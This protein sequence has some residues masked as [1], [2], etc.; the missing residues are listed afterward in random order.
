MTELKF[1]WHGKEVKNALHR[2]AAQ[3]IAKWADEVLKASQDEVPVSKWAR[4]GY[5]KS[6]GAVDMDERKLEATVS[7][8]TDFAVWVHERMD[9]NHPVGKAKFLEDPLNNVGGDKILQEA[10]KRELR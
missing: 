5:L 3:G 4:G 2:G 10:I 9:V 1:K 6:T 7:Y 8:D